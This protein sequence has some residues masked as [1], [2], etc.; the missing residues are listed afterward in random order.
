MSVYNT[1]KEISFE[2]IQNMLDNSISICDFFRKIE[3]RDVGGNRKTLYRFIENNGLSLERLVSNRNKS[4]LAGSFSVNKKEEKD[5]L[6]ENSSVNRNVVKTYIIKNKLLE[7]KCFICDNKGEWLNKEIVLHLDH[8]NG[9]G[10][11]NRLD[12]L[13][14]L[15]PN[16]HSQTETYAGKNYK[17]C[18]Y[19]SEEYKKIIK[20]KKE[21]DFF[22]AKRC[23]EKKKNEYEALVKERKEILDKIDYTKIGWVEETSK[24]W[25][26]SHTQVR[27]WVKEHYSDMPVYIRA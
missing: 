20:E 3:Q 9:I 17:S 15:C 6:C 7:Y 19:S 27:R 26:V 8:I 11:D 4:V 21:K 2:E 24:K 18:L 10:N 14:F 12:N 13:R 5:I 1:L 22:R 25:G 16:C 23:K